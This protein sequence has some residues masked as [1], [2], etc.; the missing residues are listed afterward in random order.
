MATTDNNGYD[1]SR[2][3]RLLTDL[4]EAAG[5]ALSQSDIDNKWA[6]VNCG[7]LDSAIEGLIDLSGASHLYIIPS[8]FAPKIKEWL[9]SLG[10]PGPDDDDYPWYASERALEYSRLQEKASLVDA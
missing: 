8:S 10:T 7:E 1:E 3:I 5:P 4:I 2:S 6:A 9:D